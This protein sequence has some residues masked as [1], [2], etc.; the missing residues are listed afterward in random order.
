MT[1]RNGGLFFRGLPDPFQIRFFVGRR[2][3]WAARSLFEIGA[4]SIC[5]AFRG[6]TTHSSRMVFSWLQLELEL[7]FILSLRFIAAAWL[8][9]FHDINGLSFR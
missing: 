9:I 2:R 1:R 6:V 4:L 5:E 7:L 8:I 3:L